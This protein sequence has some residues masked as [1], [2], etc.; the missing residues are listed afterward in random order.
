[1]RLLCRFMAILAVFALVGTGNAVPAPIGINN[2]TA[3]PSATRA[4]AGLPLMF[5]SNA[6]QAT[7]EYRFIARGKQFGIFLPDQEAVL[8]LHGSK[9]TS[10]LTMRTLGDKRV[11]PVGERPIF[12]R[13]NYIFGDGHEI[14]PPAV[15]QRVHYSGVYPRIDLAYYGYA[16][17]L[18]YD[19]IV[20]PGADTHKIRLA[21]DGAQS[22]VVGENGDLVA[23]VGE[24]QVRWQ[25]PLAYQ[26]IAGKKHMVE[27][28]YKADG[29]QF[30]FELGA[31]D[32]GRKLV[33]DPVLSWSTYLGGST[34]SPGNLEPTFDVVEAVA[35]DSA[36]NVYVAGTTSSTDFPTTPG[37]LNP[38][39]T[40]PDDCGA[41]GDFFCAGAFWIAKLSAGGARLIYSTYYLPRE[42]GGDDIVGLGVDSNGRAYLA[43]GGRLTIFNATGSAVAFTTGIKGTPEFSTGIR[44]LA[45][46]ANGVAYIAGSTNDPGLPV[47]PNAFQPVFAF[48]TDGGSDGF[49]AKIDPSFSGAEAFRYFSYLGGSEDESITGIATIAGNVYLTGLTSSTDFPTTSNAPQPTLKDGAGS[50]ITKINTNASGA[51]SL[52]YSTHLRG[53][54]AVAISVDSA[55][56][57]VVVGS[58]EGFTSFVT[59]PGVI[60]PTASDATDSTVTVL[61][62]SGSA[63]LMSTFLGGS[64][65]EETTGVRVDTSRN[66]HVVGTT[67]S[68]N[69]PTTADALE[70]TACINCGN[71]DS[72]YAKLSFDGKRLLYSTYVG[73]SN[74]SGL[75]VNP[76]FIKAIATDS[77]NNAYIVGETTASAFAVTGGVV[78]P[79]LHGGED[80]FIMKFAN[81]SLCKLSSTDPSV[82]LCAPTPGA[83]VGRTMRVLAGTTNTQR[84]KLMQVYIDGI[85]KYDALNA[86]SFEAFFPMTIGLHR[87][88]VQARDSVGRLTSKSVTVTVQ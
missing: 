70:R 58:T 62:A 82:T 15:F 33:I 3:T 54:K 34:P 83:T 12:T 87:V 76:N 38:K 85:K 2:E 86:G 13:V 44:S 63:F 43:S 59:T 84:I 53:T 50:F 5:E 39:S 46:G 19:F 1:M 48:S 66:I 67:G 55:G 22:V 40:I 28:R 30:N 14:A 65:I 21:L 9:K 20:A 75:P 36:H 72:Y 32:R 6:G 56:D 35:V 8:R 11:V 80:G 74:S 37:T 41:T 7:A 24:Q 47:T 4:V 60:Q 42:S 69:F 18:E 16:G 49:F 79:K 23:Q 73:G 29:G 31:Y 64:D 27:A 61:N 68:L 88:T 10:V 51:A 71:G 45:V 26:I 25:K 78:Q 17:R 52:V 77:A 81:S 57:A